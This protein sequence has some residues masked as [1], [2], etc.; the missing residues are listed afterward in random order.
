MDV[1]TTHS[2]DH[3]K[4]TMLV[5][6]REAMDFKELRVRTTYPVPNPTKEGPGSLPLLSNRRTLRHIIHGRFQYSAPPPSSIRPE[7]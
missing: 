5:D 2:L 1:G 6:I 3:I 7:D 4:N